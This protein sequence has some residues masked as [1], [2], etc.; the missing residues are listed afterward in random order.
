MKPHSLTSICFKFSP[1]I[2]LPPRLITWSC[3]LRHKNHKDPRRPKRIDVFQIC[4]VCRLNLLLDRPVYGPTDAS[5]RNLVTPPESE[6]VWWN[7]SLTSEKKSWLYGG[8][9]QILLKTICWLPV[10]AQIFLLL[11][12]PWSDIRLF[13]RIYHWSRSVTLE[14]PNCRTLSLGFGGQLGNDVAMSFLVFTKAKRRRMG[15]DDCSSRLG[16]TKAERLCKKWITDGQCLTKNHL[17]V[18]ATCRNASV[19]H[20]NGERINRN[21]LVIRVD[22]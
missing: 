14:W 22:S 3:Y 16:P 10:V 18:S 9:H 12:A 19:M 5:S 2:L 1:R 15:T 21:C 13:P 4:S 7:M 11:A 20:S 8:T 17:W 6:L